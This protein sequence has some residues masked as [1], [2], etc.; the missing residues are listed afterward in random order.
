[1]NRKTLIGI[2]TAVVI[3]GGTGAAIVV[4]RSDTSA[5]ASSSVTQNTSN[6]VSPEIVKGSLASLLNTSDTKKCSFDTGAD[7]VSA[8]VYLA[9]NRMRSDY[10]STSGGTVKEGSMI[11]LSDKQYI[12]DSADKKGVMFA[13]SRDQVEQQAGAASQQSSVDI[14][15]EYDFTCSNWTLDESKFT[16]PTDVAFTDYT[17]LQQQ[18]RN[19]DQ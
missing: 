6:T 19:F 17:Q 5:P 12:W 4:A 1:M 3:V 13:F 16:P 11:V 2:I 8:T 18:L 7:G 10:S 9:N 14:N 15:K